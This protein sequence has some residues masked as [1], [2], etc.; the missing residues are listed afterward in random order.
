MVSVLMLSLGIYVRH[1]TQTLL[2]MKMMKAE[3]K[4]DLNMKELNYI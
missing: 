4:A 3:L 2:S 1:V